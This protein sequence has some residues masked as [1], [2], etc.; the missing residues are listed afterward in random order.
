MKNVIAVVALLSVLTSPVF[1]TSTCTK[2]EYAELKDMP[3]KELLGLACFYQATHDTD[4]TYYKA[5]RTLDHERANDSFE[6]AQQ[7]MEEVIKIMHAGKIEKLDC[8]KKK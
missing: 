7:C 4:M 3:Q 5:V 2:H 6:E 8:K 1:A